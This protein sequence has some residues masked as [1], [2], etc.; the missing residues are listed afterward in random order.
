MS[1]DTPRQ[2][3]ARESDI[4]LDLARQTLTL[5]G[6]WVELGCYTGDTSIGLAKLLRDTDKQLYLY[7]SF[8]GLPTKSQQDASTIG[9]T[10]K[11]GE[12]LATKAD[13]IL[14]FKRAGLRVPR[15]KKAWF[16]D[17]TLADL[18]EQI[19]FA[20][21]DGDYYQSIKDSLKLVTPK[22]SK[23]SIVIIHDYSNPLL[24]GVAQAVDE[25]RRAHPSDLQT[26]ETLAIISQK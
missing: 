15:I 7:D 6:D 5:D 17:L 19:S 12:L 24:P 1:N 13:L 3:S 26:R 8:A 4:I 20:F 22:L 2:V 11:P 14:R 25:W 23:G 16:S 18:P 10:F 21:L 9:N